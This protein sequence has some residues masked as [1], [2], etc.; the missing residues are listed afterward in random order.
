MGPTLSTGQAAKLC[1]VKADTVLKWVRAGRLRAERTAGG[2]F[3]I[4]EKDLNALLGAKRANAPRRQAEP[5]TTP[6]R[7][8]EYLSNCGEIRR[9]CRD[10]VV[11][12]VRAA[13]CFEVAG[14]ADNIGHAK[15]FCGTSCDQCTY[16]QRVMGQPIS[17]LVVTSDD[18]LIRSLKADSTGGIALHFARN[19]YEAS[20]VVAEFRPAFVVVDQEVV[21]G[22]EPGL[23]DCL[24]SDRRVPGL[25]IVLAA[26]CGK[27]S[28]G[29]RKDLVSV[30]EKPFEKRTIA[31]VS[32]RFP[33]E[34]LA[35]R[36]AQL[37][38]Q[39][40]EARMPDAESGMNEERLDA[41]GFLKLLAGWDRATVESLARLNDI[42]PLTD[43]HWK[44]IEFVRAYY[45]AT[46]AK[47]VATACSNCKR[48]LTQLMEYHRE[49]IEVGGVHD[50]LS[51][52]ILIN[53]KAAERTD[54]T[55]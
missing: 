54:Y 45:L 51:R 39:R 37:T 53:G 42:G 24:A 41:E 34:S 20:A 16:Y 52:A 11:Y 46:G 12:R 50:M 38:E 48:Q 22:G 47:Y 35:A 9:E 2:H 13:Q 7:C 21:T 55:R 17:A 19:G 6:L 1:S 8:W 29:K 25:K 44:V 5:N 40:E 26:E 3:R 4:D 18:A 14:V 15:K 49:P 33:V 28:L 23:L 43:E 32:R 10:C 30:I 31:D 36:D 27:A